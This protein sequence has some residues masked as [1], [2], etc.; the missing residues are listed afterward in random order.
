M[1]NLVEEFLTKFCKQSPSKKEPSE[2]KI[3]NNNT[4]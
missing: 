3:I 4:N 1:M 2:Q